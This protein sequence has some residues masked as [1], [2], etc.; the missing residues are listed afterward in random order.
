MNEEWKLLIEKRREEKIKRKRGLKI[1]TLYLIRLFWRQRNRYFRPPPHSP[2]ST[3]SL[4]FPSLTPHTPTPPSLFLPR[5][6]PNFP[7][8]LLFVDFGVQLC[9]TKNY[10][11]SAFLEFSSCSNVQRTRRPDMG[12][13]T[14]DRASSFSLSSL[15]CQEDV[16][17]LTDEDPDEPTPPSDHPLPFF[18]ADDDDEYFE[19]LV[20]RETAAESGTPLLF[21]DSPDAIRSWLRSVRLDA[22]E[23]ILKVRLLSNSTS[24]L[25]D[26]SFF[27]GCV[28]FFFGI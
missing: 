11:H 6:S 4:F 15:L 28:F 19:I 8:N 27:L 18:L 10:P 21:N 25:I 3:L 22:V 26:C 2:K 9:S 1:P 24:P 17:F 12:Y 14:T 5:L 7:Q 16:S 23:W 20:A 13:T